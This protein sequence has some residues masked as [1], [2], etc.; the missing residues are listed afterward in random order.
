[1]NEYEG[2]DTAE[3]MEITELLE[4]LYNS[5]V[6]AKSVPLAREKCMLT[7][8]SVLNLLDDI[9]AQLPI[10]IS[11]SRRLLAAK[12]EFISNAR[13]EADSIRKTAEE[14]A[15]RLVEE[16]EIM[17]LARNRANELISSAEAKSKEVVRV[18]NEY[19]DDALRRTEEAIVAAATEVRSSRSRFRGLA[20]P[21]VQTAAPAAPITTIAEDDF[22]D[23]SE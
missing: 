21:T 7:R 17:Q 20:G 14:E 11:E 5:V 23:I 16:T 10:E 12:D 18:A 19:V 4:L 22:E 2:I 8:D 1:M 9:R 6:D 15:R 3:G 13:R